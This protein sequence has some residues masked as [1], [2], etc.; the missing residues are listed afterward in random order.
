MYKPTKRKA[1]NFL[2]SYFDVF[3]EIKEDADKLEFITSILNKQF[4]NEDPADLNFMVNLCY[5]SQKHAVETSVKGWLRANKDTPITNPPTN[6]PTPLGTNPPTNPKEEEEE[7]EEEEEVEYNNTKQVWPL[8]F[9]VFKKYKPKSRKCPDNVKTKIKKLS[10][11]Y[12]V[13]DFE[14]VCST[15]FEDD[16]HK[17]N[18]FRYLTMEFLTRQDK[19]IMFHELEQPKQKSSGQ[20]LP[21]LS[22]F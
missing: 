21:P 2:R 9:E 10:N 6:P 7:E 3:N 16:F 11:D 19:F 4:L 14:K 12:T 5:Q 17:S 15:A 18:G 20:T 8:W 13:N 22:S 1:F